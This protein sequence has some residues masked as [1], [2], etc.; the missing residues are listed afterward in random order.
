M[1]SISLGL[2]AGCSRQLT[3]ELMDTGCTWSPWSPSPRFSA[4]M[5]VPFLPSLGLGR[6]RVWLAVL[7]N[8][9]LFFFSSIPLPCCGP[10]HRAWL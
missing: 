6:P 5:P 7:C 8:F 2:F 1:D 3:K 4:V 10:M 9:P